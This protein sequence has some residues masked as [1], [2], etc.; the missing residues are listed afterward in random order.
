MPG[1]ILDAGA[2][3]QCAHAGQATPTSPN[4]RVLVGGQP[5]VTLPTQYTVSGCPN[6]GNAGGPCVT[7]Q[8]TTSA[9]RLISNGV[10]LLLMDSMGTCLPTSLPSQILMTQTRVSGA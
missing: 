8:F 3:V 5:T 7:G 10:P 1:F 6:P 2:T 9:T 4:T